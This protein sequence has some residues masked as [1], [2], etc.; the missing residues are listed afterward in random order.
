MV[1]EAKMRDKRSLNLPSLLIGPMSRLSA[2]LFA[3]GP[4][5]QR[6]GTVFPSILTITNNIWVGHLWDSI[7]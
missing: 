1:D 4:H 2:S 6:P 7:R 3:H 5:A